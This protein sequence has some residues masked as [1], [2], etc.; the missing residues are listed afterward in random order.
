MNN[1]FLNSAQVM[2]DDLIIGDPECNAYIT[3]L[4]RH[5]LLQDI[6]LLDV[7]LICNMANE[8][9]CEVKLDPEEVEQIAYL[10]CGEELTRNCE[11]DEPDL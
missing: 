10:I 9:S 11:W 8:Y 3:Q 1:R 6:H 5:L 4:A 2:I 7:L